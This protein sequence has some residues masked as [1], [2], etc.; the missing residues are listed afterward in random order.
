MTRFPYLDAPP[1]IGIA[2]RGGAEERPQNTIAAFRHAH[3]LGF[4]YLETDVQGTRDGALVV[5]HDDRLD[6]T[7]DRSGA[8][9][10]LT[11]DQVREARVQGEP[12]PTMMEVFATFP[13][14]R[15]N[16]EPK[17]DA[18][19]GLLAEAIRAAGAIDRV[20]IGSFKGRRLRRMR[21]LLGPRLCAGGAPLAIVRLRLAGWLG[22]WAAGPSWG[23]P[24][25][26]QIPV[27]FGPIPVADLGFVRACHRR[28]IV[29]HVWTVD[30]PD[31]MR[32]LFD[33]GVDGIM[34]DRP[35]VLRDVLDE[36]SKQD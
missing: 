33:I 26:V 30:D 20:C 12:I 31:Q 34:T 13:D 22:S 3:D 32:N 16:I 35:S 2:H 23:L 19:V 1:P 15:F 8:I 10:E 28:Q 25:I 9:A 27:K 4:R 14:A 29:V 17:S 11:L 7:T 5:F 21:K 18:A 36:R 24:P 6:P